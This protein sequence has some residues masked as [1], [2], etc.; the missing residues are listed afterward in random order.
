MNSNAESF[1]FETRFPESGLTYRR[2][3]AYPRHQTTQ[4]QLVAESGYL[5]V[6]YMLLKYNHN[7][8]QYYIYLSYPVEWIPIDIVPMQSKR[9][10]ERRRT[11][12]VEK[13]LR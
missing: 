3:V 4:G 12:L 2:H 11:P 7:W 5:H 9:L 13:Q 8:P 1:L 10:Y 6:I